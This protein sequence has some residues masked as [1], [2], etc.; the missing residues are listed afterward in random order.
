MVC[1]RLMNVTSLHDVR[2][3][4]EADGPPQD[5]STQ[6]AGDGLR[7]RGGEDR[8]PTGSRTLCLRVQFDLDLGDLNL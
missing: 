7:R 6:G 1:F 2:R 3:G 4:R 5:R 8:N